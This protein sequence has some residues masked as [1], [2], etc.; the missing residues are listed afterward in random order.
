MELDGY[1]PD[2]QLAFEY[3]G[4]QHHVANSYF[5]LLSGGFDAQLERDRLKAQQCDAEM[6]MTESS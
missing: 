3:Q 2:L 5:N 4:V 1:C 6:E